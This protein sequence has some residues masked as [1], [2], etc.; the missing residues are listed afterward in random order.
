[1][2]KQLS[3]LVMALV[4]VMVTFASCGSEVKLKRE[5]DK[6]NKQCPVTVAQG[7]KIT[8]FSDNGTDLVVDLTVNDALYDLDEM[9]T[10]AEQFKGELGSAVFSGKEGKEL[11]KLLKECDKGL[12]F[13]M[14]GQRSHKEVT[15][16]VPVN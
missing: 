9:K 14:K 10:N 12:E 15:I 5:I 13:K 8:K 16:N 6:A 2:K 7:I 11:K 3:L 4:A 1:M